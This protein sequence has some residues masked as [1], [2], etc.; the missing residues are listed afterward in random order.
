MKRPG[1]SSCLL[2]AYCFVLLTYESS[3]APRVAVFPLAGDSA[4]E[5]REKVGF[6]IRTKFARDRVYEPIDGVTMAEIAGDAPPALGAIPADVAKL[7]AHEKPAI[8]IWGELTGGTPTSVAEATLRLKVLDLRVPDAKPVDV[9]KKL[10]DPT[11]LRFVVEEIVQVVPG[12]GPIRRPNEQEVIDDDTSRALWVKNPNLIANG[13]FSAAGKWNVLYEAQK[14][15]IAPAKDLPAEDKVNI[16][17]PPPAAGEKPNPVLAMK[18]SRY[19]AENPGMACLSD[20]IP[21]A[22]GR[23]YRVSFRYQSDGPTTHVFVK[24]YTTGKDINGNAAERECFR[25]QVNPTGPTEG[26][27]RT[28]VADI[29][30]YH[31]TFKVEHL[32]VDLYAYLSPG[33]ILWDDVVVKE[34]GEL[35]KKPKDDALDKPITRPVGAK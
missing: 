15:L 5:V 25:T 30:P 12:V 26:K 2:L 16:Y 21:I 31:P 4:A 8:L 6:S 10:A 20:A 18:L 33:V 19:A 17:T 22:P 29:N 3:A 1:P 13:D 24:G 27:W 28:V 14:Y 9:T 23:R 34:I 7:A 11:D 32:R 35:T